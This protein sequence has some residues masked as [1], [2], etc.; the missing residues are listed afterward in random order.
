MRDGE[1]AH[2]EKEIQSLRCQTYTYYFYT[3]LSI[4]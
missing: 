3:R 4:V 2:M 1:E